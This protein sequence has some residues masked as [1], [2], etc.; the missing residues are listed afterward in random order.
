MHVKIL[1][2]RVA[3]RAKRRGIDVLV[4]APHFT[5]WSTIRERA[6][7]F[8]DDD[9]LVVPAR[10]LFT[11]D[12]RHRRHVLALDLQR[13]IPDFL[14]LDGAVNELAKQDAVVC[15]PHPGFLTISLERD[16]IRA[17]RDIVDA[18]EVYNPKHLPRDNRRARALA[19]EFDIPGFTSSYAHLPGTIG[20]CWTTFECA[21]DTAADLH[22]ALRDGTP[23]TATHRDGL[24]HLGRRAI[25]M[26]HIGYENT[27]KKLDRVYLSGTEPT[28][29]DHVAYGG[30][31]EDSSVY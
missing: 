4:Y 6:E 13:G 22:D 26:A 28:H 30:A 3:A 8:S 11:G 24:E 2:E 27:W 15:V 23:R 21:I 12:W 10:E 18:I 31:F 14:T 29:P 25:E 16:H 20:E 1:D 19:A 17:Y 5:R 7:R 9:L